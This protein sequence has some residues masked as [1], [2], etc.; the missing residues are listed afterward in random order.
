[1]KK[2]LC[3]LL[4]VIMLTSMFAV[5]ADEEVLPVAEEKVNA[6]EE[7][8]SKN[9]KDDADKTLTYNKIYVDLKLIPRMKVIDSFAKLEICTKDDKV[10]EEKV[11][12]VG[13]I[14]EK[15][16]FEFDVPEYSLGESFILKLK[17]GLRYIKYYDDVYTAEQAVKLDTYGYT[18]DN[19]EFVAGNR[20]ALDG[21]PEYE[22]GIVA[23]VEGKQ[24]KLS[25]YGRLINNVAMVPVRPVAEAMGLDVRYDERY[26]SVVCE[27]GGK[28][29]IFNVGMKYSTLLG[30]D[31]Y[32]PEACTFIGDTVFVPAR[33]LA[34]AFG[35]EVKALDFDDHID[36]C[37]GESPVVK[38]YMQ[39]IPVNKY[40]ITSRTSYLVWV[41]KSDY[42]VRVYT[43]SQYKWKQVASFP[44][45]IGA[46]G[47]PTITGS[48]EYQYKVSSWNYPG[49]YVG[50]CLVFY[51]GYALHSTLLQYNGV[52]YD[53]RVGVMISHG[54]V[55][56]HKSDIDWIAA[57]LPIGSRI[58][59]T[60]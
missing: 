53:N 50:P 48:F 6:L 49:Y 37:I 47:T 13:G 11:E 31:T 38:E 25:P 2:F 5:Y 16:S 51:G 12:W 27:I 28:Q 26:N 33:S 15:L 39:Q 36:V 21:C 45:A 17:G 55:R 42:R 14:T 24:I 40:G 35:A 56:L 57:R 54:C 10:I 32:L 46:P 3:A 19:G 23:Y 52:P 43:G 34:E 4:T 30:T 8:T 1:M 60:E 59:V 20:F 18:D 44:C 58:Y 22:H 29:A 9:E 7:E 41:D